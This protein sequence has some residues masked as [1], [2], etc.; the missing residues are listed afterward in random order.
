VADEPATLLTTAQALGNDLV[1]LGSRMSP[2]YLLTFTVFSL[3]LFTV[4]PRDSDRSFLQWLLPASIYRNTSLIVD[5]QLFLTAGLLGLAGVFS[6]VLISAIC[7]EAL[8]WVLSSALGPAAVVQE[9]VAASTV[10][11]LAATFVFTIGTDFSLYWAHRLAHDIP[12]LWPFHEVH[13]SAEVLAPITVSRQHPF[14]LFIS[15]SIVGIFVGLFGAVCMRLF[16]EAMP[17]L[18]VTK[19]QVFTI[20]F[21][22]LHAN[23]R[24]SHIWISYGPT[25]EHVFMSPA[26]HQLHHSILPK[27][28]HANFG[29]MLSVWDWLFGTLCL[30]GDER[31]L[32][33]G[34]ATA[35][36][37]R[38]APLHPTW[39]DAML[40]PFMRVGQTL[41]G[42]DLY[43]A[44]AAKTEDA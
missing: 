11:M 7:F 38:I 29:S 36:G 10:A 14:D 39:K 37:R 31:P 19:V 1:G 25:A 9:P 18:T 41:A 8:S 5:A 17:L 27:H 44:P 42:E 34:L 23:F 28:H 33:F 16:G 24:H 3:V 15:T 12:V 40:V 21:Y 32:D 2:L 35:D 20:A 13:H 22:A 6:P 30:A 43:P 26:Q 4:R